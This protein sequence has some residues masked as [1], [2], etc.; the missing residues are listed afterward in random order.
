MVYPLYRKTTVWLCHIFRKK[1]NETSRYLSSTYIH[2]K[3]LIQNVSLW[4]KK[5]H[6]WKKSHHS[7]FANQPKLQEEIM[8]TSY[9]LQ[10]MHDTREACSKNLKR[11][12][13]LFKVTHISL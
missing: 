12:L 13:S 5:F 3:I 8:L 2:E 6:L 7:H 9:F 11:K 1:Q 4:E 10:K